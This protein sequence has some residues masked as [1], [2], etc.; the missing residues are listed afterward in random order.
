MKKKNHSRI[1]FITFFAALILPLINVILLGSLSVITGSDI[2]YPEM[3]SQAL[4]YLKEL[5]NVMCVFAASGCLAFSQILD[6]RIKTVRTI[7]LVSVPVNYLAAAMVDMGFYG[8]SAFSTVYLLPM[9]INCIFELA[10]YLVVIL[11][12]SRVGRA[13]QKSKRAMTL[14][15]F[16]LEGTM[17]RT[18]VFTT[19]T[20]FITLIV[21][22]LTDTISLL[23]EYGA[24]LNSSELTYLIVPYPTAIVYS[25]IGY[26]VIF[27]VGR[28]FSAGRRA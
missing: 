5:I 19:L 20:V 2:V 17:S 21:T 8:D 26:L 1:V 3:L 16:S 22:S 9:L 23:A 14:E 10:R 11:V 25:V 7:C 28:S 27:L 13:A 15:L 4:Q 6:R 18:A 12:A 24:P